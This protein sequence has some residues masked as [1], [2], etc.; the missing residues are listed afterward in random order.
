[1]LHGIPEP[2]VHDEFSYLLGADTFAHGRL[3]NPPPALPEFF[4]S[5]HVL[6]TPTYN[7]KYP[8]T[9]S[10]MLAVGQILSGQAIWGVWLGCGIFAA[11]LCW[12]LQAWTCRRWALATTI[13]SISTLG[14]SSY[15]AQS[16]WGGMMAATGS[17]LLFGGT[18][19]AMR[20]PAVVP[21]TLAAVGALILA[22]TR[23][24]EG[25]LVFVP[26]TIPLVTSFVRKPLTDLR[27]AAVA[28][29]PAAAVLVAGIIG[30]AYYNQAVTGSW[31]RSP[32]GLHLQQYFRQGVFLFSPQR[33]P[34]RLPLSRVARF[35]EA[36]S[37]EPKHG[38]RLIAR[39][40]VNAYARLPASIEAALGVLPI[41]RL[42]D[43]EPYRALLFWLL[44]L[45]MTSLTQRWMLFCLGTVVLVVAGESLVWWWYPH[46]ASPIVPIVLAAMA[47]A[48]R[49]LSRLARA[50]RAWQR[51]V[52]GA[53]ALCAA[54]FTTLPVI[55]GSTLDDIRS[56]RL[57][58]QASDT[59]P[60]EKAARNL[61]A[62]SAMRMQLEQRGGTHLV[63]VRYADEFSLHIEWVYN[64]ADLDGAKV[65]FAHDLGARRNAAL[66][67][68]YAGRSIWIASVSD[69]Q[70]PLMPYSADAAGP[71][72]H[73]TTPARALPSA[74]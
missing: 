46:Y 37:F 43:R 32:Y 55:F 65:I 36:N 18:R 61:R 42:S 8:P 54:M 48:L 23:P 27:S 74:R 9:Q 34:D 2:A 39:A 59:S 7:S 31:Q 10:L 47:M 69:T 66:I 17:A 67:A 68:A 14:V 16:Y 12:M 15:W 3:T 58:A 33:V 6:V 57:S 38:V 73:D 25:L 51:R 49:R 13:V 22:T 45:V 20:R 44:L 29:V 72:P 4:E 50:P 19:R 28:L 52:P 64:S 41:A 35:Y 24:Y 30:L 53:I 21:S 40:A 56:G 11:S 60:Q 5:P 63:F 71:E 62:R 70:Q 1:M 26:A